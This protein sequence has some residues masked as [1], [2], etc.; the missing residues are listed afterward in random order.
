MSQFEDVQYELTPEPQ[1]PKNRYYLNPNTGEWGVV[2]L[3]FLN[4]LPP[5]QLTPHGVQLVE[6]VWAV[7]AYTVTV[8]YHRIIH[9]D[10]PWANYG[11]SD[12]VEGQRIE[13]DRQMYERLYHTTEH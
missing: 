2:D 1:R 13:Q 3:T 11:E 7:T 8:A 4:E 6:G 5:V 9:L 12:R 10:T